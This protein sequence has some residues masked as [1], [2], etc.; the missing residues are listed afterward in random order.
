MDLPPLSSTRDTLGEALKA[1]RRA[2]EVSDLMLAYLGQTLS[3]RGPV[4]PIKVWRETLPLLNASLPK[5]VRL[6]TEFPVPEIIILADALQLRQVLI[7]LVVNAG[8]AIGDRVGEITVAVSLM[9]ATEIRSPG[10]FPVNWEPKEEAYVC[11]SV[12]DEGGGM[13]PAILE[14]IFDPFFTTKLTGRGLGLAVV[15]GLVGAQEGA[16][17]VENEPG[18]APPFGF[19]C[20]CP[21]RHCCRPGKRR[22]SFPA[23]NR[24]GYGCSWWKMKSR[25]VLWPRLCCG[26]WAMR[27]WRR[28][29]ESRPLRCFDG[30]RNGSAVCCSTSP[31]RAGTAGR[32]W[33]PSGPCGRICR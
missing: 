7:N 21:I 4:D 17:A 26:G 25:F 24:A 3:Q 5:E 32:P 22:R 28:S 14:K 27:W 6:K 8:E 1:S 23:L 16:L 30:I 31:C 2:A 12:S 33:Q 19:S 29:M 20:P 18:R 15:L 10:F 9:P 13:D 11:L